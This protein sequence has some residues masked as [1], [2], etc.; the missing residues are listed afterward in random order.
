MDKYDYAGTENPPQNLGDNYDYPA[1]KQ[2][3]ECCGS[4]SLNLG[5]SC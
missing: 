2:L 5:T 1:T 4:I 3:L